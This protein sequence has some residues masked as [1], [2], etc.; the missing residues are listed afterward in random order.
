MITEL[1]YGH[2]VYG[3]EDR[4]VT[5]ADRAATET[6]LAGS[7][8]SS[9][10]GLLVDFFPIRKSISRSFCRRSHIFTSSVKHYPIWLPGS[11]FKVRTNKIRRLVRDMLDIPYNIVREHAVS[12]SHCVK[13]DVFDTIFTQVSGRAAPCFTANLLY[14]YVEGGS[15]LSQEDEVDIKGAAGVLYAGMARSL[16]PV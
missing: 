10:L 13:S 1:T 5:L 16:I 12:P 2:R 9:V 11:G 14:Q 4:F 8:G 3:L 6:V 7:P 15:T